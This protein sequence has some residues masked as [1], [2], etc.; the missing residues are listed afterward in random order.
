[1]QNAVP[2]QLHEISVAFASYGLLPRTAATNAARRRRET[3][4]LSPDL[5]SATM[6]RSATAVSARTASI[7]TSA[8][9]CARTNAPP[10][11]ASSAR[12][13]SRKR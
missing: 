13:G 12:I 11:R 8:R 5:S 3:G 4:T 6:S 7:R 9:R 10:T 2:N 1:M